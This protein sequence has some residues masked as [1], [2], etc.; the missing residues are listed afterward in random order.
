M[1]HI[2]YHIVKKYNEGHVWCIDEIISL[3]L[4][5]IF[6]YPHKSID[7]KNTP[8]GNIEDVCNVLNG[9]LGRS[10]KLRQEISAYSY[11]SLKQYFNDKLVTNLSWNTK[12]HI[13]NQLNLP[14][15][16][17]FPPFL[18]LTY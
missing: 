5:T 8:C 9:Y 12:K 2:H 11:E 17:G 7:H 1:K 4:A 14:P 3:T 18:P 6:P 13:V 10:K 15:H 16:W